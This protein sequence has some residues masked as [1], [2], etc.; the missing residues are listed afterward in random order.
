MIHS[1]ENNEK[2][3]CFNEFITISLEKRSKKI[4]VSSNI[5]MQNLS[6]I[7]PAINFFNKGNIKSIYPKENKD[8]S[9]ESHEIVDEIGKGKQFNIFLEF[10][11]HP[12]LLNIS[13]P[14]ILTIKLYETE[15]FCTFQLKL[16]YTDNLPNLPLHSISP[17]QI[18]SGRI[19]LKQNELVQPSNLKFFEHG[20]QSWSYSK[21]KGN[22]EGYE[23]IIVDVIARIHQNHD[24]TLSGDFMSESVTMISDRKSKGSLCLGF[25]THNRCFS[26]VVLNR[27]KNPSEIRWLSA[28]SQFDNIIL[29]LIEMDPIS[30]EELLIGFHP[31]QGYYS[32]LNYAEITGKKMHVK[33]LP[34]RIG[35][36]SWYYYYV[37]ITD[38]ELLKN[39]EFF[40][41]NPDLPVDM[42]QLDDGYFTNV[43]DFTSFNSK[44]PNGLLEFVEETHNQGKKAGLWIAP[45]F[46]TESSELFRKNPSWFLKN[47]TGEFIPVCFN[48][49]E[50]EY[51]LDVTYPEVQTHLINLIKKITNEWKFDFI[52]IDF[53]Y[54]ASIYQSVYYKKGLTRAQVY[55]SALQLIRDAMGDNKYILGCGA[56]L[57]PSIG[58]VDAM[59]VSEDTKEVWK[60]DV[61]PL[62]GDPCLKYALI[63]TIYRSFTHNSL[64]INDPDCLIVRRNRSSL[65]E[66]EVELQITIF[67]LSGGQIFISD[68][69]TGIE[70][71]RLNL[72]LKIIP[73]IPKSAIPLDA[74]YEPLP[75]L[76]FLSTQVLNKKRLL[77]TVINWEDQPIERNFSITKILTLSGCEITTDQF[78][79]FDWWNEQ[80]IGCFKKNEL[81]QLGTISPHSCKYLGIIPYQKD[82]TIFISSTVHIAQGSLEVV[83]FNLSKSKLKIELKLPG[84][85]QGK[86]FI[87]LPMNTKVHEEKEN[88]SIQQTP[89][90]LLYEI[91]VDFIDYSEVSLIFK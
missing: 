88:H 19:V 38:K 10:G 69:M 71:E 50:I 61:E 15:N 91:F 65:T 8:F 85:H 56:P 24:N 26:R 63:A 20:F 27:L 58:L 59:R 80:L 49:N 87:L 48:W 2:F 62:Y 6:G 4:L 70:A 39:V 11:N 37:D 86:L 9:V 67:G 3:T 89:W 33:I 17:L 7:R 66:K 28:Y 79:V 21:L 81:V 60:T 84:R 14:M 53:I 46:A 83:N 78:I 51:A 30:S 75:T 32:L 13:F 64:W 41:S 73:P 76:Y 35:W 16:N 74:L 31:F 12:D 44:F 55:R 25:I 45:F 34:P 54:A 42:I 29:N 47:A 1:D 5:A 72:A 82:T 36:C 18:T 43:G 52:K 40:K 23:S 22:D 68:D 77:I 57:G 90:G